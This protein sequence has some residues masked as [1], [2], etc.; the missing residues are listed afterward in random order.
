MGGQCTFNKVSFKHCS[1]LILAATQATLQELVFKH[2]REYLS[3]ISLCVQ[4]AGTKVTLSGSSITGATEGVSVQAGVSV[5]A[6]D[7]TITAI[8][9][10]GAEVKDEGTFLMLSRCKLH[11]FSPEAMEVAAV[12]GVHVHTSSRSELFSLSITCP[13]RKAGD[14]VLTS[15]SATLS[16][17]NVSHS[18]LECVAFT[19]GSSG[20]LQ[21]CTISEAKDDGILVYGPGSSAHVSH[22]DV[23][24]CV[25]GMRALVGGCLIAHMCKTFEK[26]TAG[27]SVEGEGSALEV[28]GCT[29]HLD[30]HGCI[31]AD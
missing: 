28:T 7:L 21:G 23:R 8:G 14:E 25:H 29:S 3:G 22:C 20:Q 1:L 11:N 27:Y 31:A 19:D 6:T 9:V 24:D 15:A 12:R 26:N 16:E 18:R 30:F 10:T 4:G 5:E 2:A 17:S 13:H